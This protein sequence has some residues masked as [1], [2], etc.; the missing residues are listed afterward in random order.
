MTMTRFPKLIAALSLLACLAAPSAPLSA[1]SN[2]TSKF[3]YMTT[4][5]VKPSASADFAD[6]LKNKWMP[7]MKKGGGSPRIYSGT[8][9]GG[10]TNVYMI[11]SYLDSMAMFDQPVTTLEKGAGASAY[12]RMLA[13]RNQMIDS[14]TQII[15]SRV[16]EL[17]VYKDTAQA[18]P[19][20]LVQY[21]KTLPSKQ[22]EFR[23]IWLKDV[24]PAVKKAGRAV[25][26]WRIVMGDENQFVT[27]TPLA[28]FAELDKGLSI[29]QLSMEPD[30]YVSFNNAIQPTATGLRREV[31]RLRQDLM[32]AE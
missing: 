27:S 29:A 25:S 9:A 1:Q 16:P 31:L 15:A 23:N 6:F 28:S 4:Y 12:A 19:L 20:L 11:V 8:P 17:S 22:Q 18:A 26:V 7:A 24:V 21:T 3:L 10:D 5:H 32:G 30:A 13:Q 14:R 2:T